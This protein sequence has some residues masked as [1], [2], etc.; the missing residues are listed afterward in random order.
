MSFSN[1]ISGGTTPSTLSSPLYEGVILSNTTKQKRA[2]IKQLQDE[3][4][5]FA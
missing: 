4:M 2:Q 1:R 5:T 3:F